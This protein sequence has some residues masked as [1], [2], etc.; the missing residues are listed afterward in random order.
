MRRNVAV[1][2][3][4][5]AALGIGTFNLGCSDPHETTH[6]AQSGNPGTA[7]A[8]H[9]ADAGQASTGA[10]GAGVGTGDGTGTGAGTTSFGS[11]TGAS[12]SKSAAKSHAG[13]AHTQPS[14]H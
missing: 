12:S 14:H 6:A 1:G 4:S 2:M 10:V 9:A 8:T 3:V 5:I 11:A 7:H 13:A